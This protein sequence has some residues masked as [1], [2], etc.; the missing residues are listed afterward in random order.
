MTGKEVCAPERACIITIDG[1]SGSGKSTVARMLAHALDYAYLDTGAMY[2]GVAVA[3]RRAGEV[4]DLRAFL[5][6]LDLTFQFRGVTRVYLDGTDISEEIREPAVSLL[7]SALSQKREIRDYLTARQRMIGASGGLVVE[8]RD[9]GSVV[10]PRADFKFYLDAALEERARRRHLELLQK[11]MDRPAQEVM[12]EM[13]KRDRDD[14][15][16]EIAPLSVPEGAVRV[17]TTG[18]EPPAVIDLLVT[19]IRRKGEAWKQ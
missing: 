10:F 6:D 14:S 17:D 12:E 15:T 19:H 8:G 11:G 7:A 4:H 1:P 3:L 9:A 18:I 5:S 2:R 13:E 16:R